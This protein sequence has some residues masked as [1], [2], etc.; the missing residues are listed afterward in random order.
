MKAPQGQRYRYPWREHNQFELL[1]DSARFYPRMLSAIAEAEQLI[2]LEQYLVASGRV[3]ERFID[4]LLEARARGVSVY[5][6]LDD[7][8]AQ[9]TLH[10]DRQRLYKAGVRL[11]FYNPFR[12][13]QLY[14]SLYRDHRKLLLIDDKKAYVGGAGL[15]DMYDTDTNAEHHWHDVMVEVRGEVLADW[16]ASF[17][18]LWRQVS[19]APLPAAPRPRAPENQRGRVVV[20]R[21][22]FRNE[23]TRAVIARMKRSRHRIW[24]STPYFITTKRLRR[25]LRRTA[26]RGLDVRL[27]LPGPYTD[28]PW[29]RFAARHYYHRLLRDGVRIFEFQPRFIHAKIVLCDDWVSLGS[30]NLDRWNQRWNLDA[31]QIIDHSAT[32]QTVRQLFETDFAQ[33]EEIKLEYWQK[34]R[35]PLR[36][37]EWLAIKTVNLIAL[38][39]RA[40][41]RHRD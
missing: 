26:H 23:I 25:Q 30:S 35:W 19:D 41:P 5:V 14:R 8:G 38:M 9:A 32:A 10:G 31:N 17:E 18:R 6:L 13:S 34:R 11:V 4:A 3:L 2:L 22:P 12:W 29:L 21:G 37:A 15:V 28:H 16:Y 40:L 24:L 27:L 33:S 39:E 1:V 7:Y 36:L 20:A